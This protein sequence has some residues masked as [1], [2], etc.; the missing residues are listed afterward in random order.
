MPEVTATTRAVHFG[1]THQMARVLAGA[2]SSR[3]GS[4]E[5]R[6]ARAALVLASR[7]EQRLA[8]AGA[9]EGAGALLRVQ[10][11]GAGLL[12]AVLTQHLVGLRAK[13]TA[14][15]FVRLLD[16][17]WFLGHRTPLQAL[18]PSAAAAD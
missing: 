11:A 8:A 9:L 12:G 16:R 2:D 10:R 13:L 1:A 18:R 6:P 7:V 17:K 3:H 4:E 5:A 15:L 14:P